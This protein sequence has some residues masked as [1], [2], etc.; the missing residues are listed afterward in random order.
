[1]KT[2]EKERIKKLNNEAA[3]LI[4]KCFYDCD[5]SHKPIDVLED[6]IH[7]KYNPELLVFVLNCLKEFDISIKDTYFIEK[8]VNS[9]SLIIKE[10]FDSFQEAENYAK[11]LQFPK[12]T[13]SIK[14]L[15]SIK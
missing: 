10:F 11:N 2:T 9:S 13:Y 5:D 6:L 8:Q 15:N 1:M 14:K 3:E 12:K 7:M 4:D